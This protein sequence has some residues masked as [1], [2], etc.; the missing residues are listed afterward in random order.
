M[1][2]RTKQIRT[3]LLAAAILCAGATVHADGPNPSELRDLFDAGTRYT[4]RVEFPSRVGDLGDPESGRA[5]FGVAADGVS[6]DPSQG[7]FEGTSAYAGEVVGNGRTCFSCHQAGSAH[8]GLPPLPL[9]A[10]VAADDPLLTGFQADAGD[11]PL[12]FTNLDELGLILHKP[13]RFNP[14][15]AEDD[16]LRQVFF[17]RRST[18]LL[19]TVFTFGI[20]GDG[21]ARNLVEATRGAVFSHTQNGN[22][23]FHDIVD[24]QRLQDISAFVEQQI[25]PPELVAL[26]DSSDPMYQTLVNDPF[27]TVDVETDAEARGRDVFRHSC[28]SCH[29]TPN[30]FSNIDHVNGSAFSVAPHYGRP[31]DVGVAQRN[32]LH[33]E[34]RRYDAQTGQRVPITI[35]LIRED[36][37][38]VQVT[39]VDDVGVAGATGRY[40]DLHRFKVPQLRRVRQLGPYF[41]DNSA[42][43]LE[44]VVDYFNSDD[45]N[46]STDGRK[47]PI[48]L[49]AHQR[50]DLL[51]FLNVL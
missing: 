17:W 8:F 37:A 36:G 24:V 50:A 2:I 34:F 15:L 26:L 48:H 47:H 3:P 18:R 32:A 31:M 29:N 19:N 39:V 11:D 6:G 40:E 10:S 46:H 27:Y 14:L 13:N 7:L 49:N 4:Q 23:P 20:L 45:Y 1:T 5:N 25:D 35:P 30:V 9:H 42:A 21:R 12:G 33:L 43:T 16:P 41:H 44:D 51:A 22:L 28:M 38:T